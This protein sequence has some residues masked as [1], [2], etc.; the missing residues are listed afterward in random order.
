MVHLDLLAYLKKKIKSK[1][2]VLPVS[3]EDEATFVFVFFIVD[4]I[5][6]GLDLGGTFFLF[7]F[8][9]A[10]FVVAVDVEV[11]V[12][13]LWVSRVVF[14][15]EDRSLFFFLIT[16]VAIF[17]LSIVIEEECFNLIC[18]P[19]F[20]CSSFNKFVNFCKSSSNNLIAL[21]SVS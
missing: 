13:V 9:D 10:I 7:L 4:E 5:W 3:T 2:K 16:G 6:W 12:S 19:F 15:L 11:E 1:K 20:S 21:S 17:G 8:S 18:F 14:V